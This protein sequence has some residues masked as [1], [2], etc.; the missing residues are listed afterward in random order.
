MTRAELRE[1]LAAFLG[2][3]SETTFAPGTGYGEEVR[4]DYVRADMIIALFSQS[5]P[6]REA[7]EFMTL[8]STCPGGAQITTHW[9]QQTLAR[10]GLSD[11]DRSVREKL[12]A[13]P[14]VKPQPGKNIITTD[15]ARDMAITVCRG[16]ENLPDDC[17]PDKNGSCSH[18]TKKGEQ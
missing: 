3:G 11:M 4:K 9:M 8:V 17:F 1:Q 16:C 12:I 18:Y 15:Q 6:F 7:L 2:G 10:G 5:D 14:P 13:H